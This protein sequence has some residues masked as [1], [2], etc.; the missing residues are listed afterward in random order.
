M[1]ISTR[2]PGGRAR[3]SFV[4]LEVETAT[5]KRIVPSTT[6]LRWTGRAGRRGE[7]FAPRGTR[8]SLTRRCV[9][10]EHAAA[11][12]HEAHVLRRAD[13]GERIARHRDDVG[14]LAGFER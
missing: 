12:H 13:V 9:V 3:G 1:V 5:W 10:A 8:R 4:P 7:G 6:S 11:L 2:E 14:L